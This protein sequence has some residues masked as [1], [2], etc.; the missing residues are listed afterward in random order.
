MGVW[1]E[2]RDFIN[3]GNIISLAVAFV[4]GTAFAAVV[5][6]LVTD[7]INPIIGI[8]GHQDFSKFSLVVNGS[9]IL[10][11][12]FINALIY[13][14]IVALVIFFAIVRPMAKM[15]ERQ[16]AKQAAA[17]P[18]TKECPFCIST[19]PIKATKCPNCTSSLSP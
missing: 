1:Q 19:I 12:S 5:S 4:I 3:K 8:P 15:A 13:F 14:V 11:G 7:I 10:Y 17:P 16:K 6:A 18:T 9:T 2:S